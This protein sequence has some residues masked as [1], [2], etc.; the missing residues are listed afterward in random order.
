[1][2][3]H[4]DRTQYIKTE[5][6]EGVRLF[7][8]DYRQSFV[9]LRP[10]DGKSI[11]E[12]AAAFEKDTLK[13]ALSAA[14]MRDVDLSMPKFEQEDEID[15]SDLLRDMELGIIF[16]QNQADFS[17]MGTM[18]GYPLFVSKVIQK[19]AVRVD[20]RGTEA[21]VATEVEMDTAALPMENQKGPVKLVLDSP[22]AYFIM[23]SES[24]IPL[25]MGVMD[26][27]S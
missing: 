1:M 26:D 15:M 13:N 23:D 7:Y 10:T 18:N 24:G 17:K 25:F 19:S 11:H 9:A 4:E 12:F 14:E 6:A 5:N 3:K 8:N 21:A 20:E 27:P 22:Y 16:D 2:N